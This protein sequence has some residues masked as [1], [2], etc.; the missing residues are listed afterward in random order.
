VEPKVLQDLEVPESEIKD[1]VVYQGRGCGACNDIGYKGRIAIYEVMPFSEGL[2][3]LL[4]QSAPLS[5]LKRQAVKD[6]MRS[7]RMSALTKLKQG[8]TTI[9]EV[10]DSS[11]ADKLG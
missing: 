11:P 9:Q 1:F 8:V 10:I 7:L 5:D 4:Y 6:G 3:T 2:K